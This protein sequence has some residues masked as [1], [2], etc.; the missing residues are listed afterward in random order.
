MTSYEQF[1]TKGIYQN[2]R[3]SRE[4]RYPDYYQPIQTFQPRNKLARFL[5]IST[6]CATLVLIFWAILSQ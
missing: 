5:L 6:I 3:F 2:L 1:A 4:L